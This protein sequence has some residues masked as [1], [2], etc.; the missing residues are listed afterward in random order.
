MLSFT[1]IF[2]LILVALS[3]GALITLLFIS[4]IPSVQQELNEKRAKIKMYQ[5]I[6]KFFDKINRF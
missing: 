3:L 5:S 4:V 6:T 1:Q 2:G